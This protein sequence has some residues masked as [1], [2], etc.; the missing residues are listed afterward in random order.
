VIPE[1]SPPIGDVGG[2][3]GGLY[4][5]TLRARLVRGAVFTV[6]S[7]LDG[8]YAVI[9]AGRLIG[10]NTVCIRVNLGVSL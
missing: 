7:F 9:I 6:R 3:I 5:S 4:V 2:R 1:R 8:V 10:I